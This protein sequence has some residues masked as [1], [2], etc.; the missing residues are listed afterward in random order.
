[1]PLPRKGAPQPPP[2]GTD[3]PRRK[4]PAACTHFGHERSTARYA[5]TTRSEAGSRLS[6]DGVARTP[7]GP[8][9]P[10]AAPT[11]GILQAPLA[12]TQASLPE[13]LECVNALQGALKDPDGNRREIGVLRAP[14][15]G[16]CEGEAVARPAVIAVWAQTLAGHPSVL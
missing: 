1:M 3:S 2:P 5:T 11:V 14:A 10:A 8:P 7:A 13:Q 6:A 12:E 4:A 15:E 9:Q 16:S